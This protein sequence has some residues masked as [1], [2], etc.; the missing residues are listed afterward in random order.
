MDRYRQCPSACERGQ[1]VRTR[2]GSSRHTIIGQVH[3]RSTPPGP[4]LDVLHSESGRAEQLLQSFLLH[5]TAAGTRR[6]LLLGN[7][8]L[9][10]RLWY[11][12]RQ[13]SK[14]E[15]RDSLQWRGA[16]P[17]KRHTNVQVVPHPSP[18]SR[19]VSW[20][21]KASA[22][23]MERQ[24]NEMALMESTDR[25]TACHHSMRARSMH[26]NLGGVRLQ[27]ELVQLGGRRWRRCPDLLFLHGLMLLRL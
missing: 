26:P 24:H 13:L 20:P 18:S 11:S 3:A 5:Q 7:A 21:W 25:L 2:D 4:H 8:S 16:V 1:M 15:K 17:V 14:F 9:A 27:A 22:I 19:A 6:S 10:L 12:K 23:R